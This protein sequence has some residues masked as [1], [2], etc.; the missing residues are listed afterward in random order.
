MQLNDGSCFGTATGSTSRAF[1]KG[2]SIVV[3]DYRTRRMARLIVCAL[4][5]SMLAAACGGDDEEPAAGG[6]GEA[7]AP[8]LGAATVALSTG[9]GFAYGYFIAEEL[10]FYDDEG[11]DVTLEP[12]G[13]SSDVA[14]ILAAGNAEAGMGVPGSMLPAIEEGANLY[15]FFTYAYGEVFDVVVPEGSDI[16]EIADLEGRTIGIS[17][18]QGGEVPLVKAL[19][20]DAGLDPDTDVE[21]LE[22]GTATPKVQ[23]AIDRGD[24]DAYSSAKSDIAKITA[25]GVALESIAPESLEELPAEGLLATD[26]TKDNHYLLIALGRATAKGQLIAYTNV[27]AAVCVLK[28]QIPEEFADE[29]AGRAS[30]EEVIG[31][32]QAPKQG[33]TYRFGFLD[34]EG[35]NTYVEIFQQGDVITS[36]IDMSKYVIDDH[37]DAINDFDQQEIV[38]MA[39]ELPTDC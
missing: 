22:I 28:K 13:G 6:G 26:E 35:W 8:D 11:V 25:A 17:E 14:Q 9:S 29:E 12:T 27:D 19:L 18:L 15:P 34:V 21:M 4:V 16:T 10:G 1:G 31:I 24:I 30:L 33:D 32:T 38:D 23:L 37:I 7:A 39:N 3:K 20:V 36:D 5:L 2:E